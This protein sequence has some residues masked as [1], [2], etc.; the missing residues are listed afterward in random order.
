MASANDPSGFVTTP[1]ST[2]VKIQGTTRDDI[3]GKLGIVVQ[4]QEDRGRY[5]VHLTS[6]QTVVSMKPDNLVKGSYVEQAQAYYEQLCKDPQV[7]RILAQMQRGLPP[8]VTLKHAGMGFGAFLLVMVYLLGFSRTLM[9]VSFY[10]LPIN[11]YY[12]RVYH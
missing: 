1:P 4:Y 11:L 6:N 10:K 8:G 7:Q 3:N 12:K 2:I 9:L 5:L